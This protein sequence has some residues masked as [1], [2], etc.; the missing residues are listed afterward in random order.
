MTWSILSIYALTL[1]PKIH[2]HGNHE[3]IH[4]AIHEHEHGHEHFSLAEHIALS[5]DCHNAVYHGFVEEC[6][7]DHMSQEDKDCELCQIL[8]KNK[9]EIDVDFDEILQP[10]VSQNISTISGS[11]HLLTFKHTLSN[12]GPPV[13]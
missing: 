13:L 3:H 8:S 11:G 1:L 6:G 10:Y 2:I 4:N 5:S 12:R 9:T 7:H